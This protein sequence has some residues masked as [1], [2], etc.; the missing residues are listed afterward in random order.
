LRRL[1]K[2]SNEALT[3]A[4]RVGKPRRARN[5]LQRLIGVFDQ[6]ARGLRAQ[7]LDGL[8]RR[9]PGL[10]DK[11]AAELLPGLV[12][13]RIAGIVGR[14]YLYPATDLSSCAYLNIHH[15]ENYAN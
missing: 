12:R 10:R 3:H 5:R 13:K 14:Q 2:G 6:R 9:L 11:G 4:L 1:A 8:G 15:I 7:A